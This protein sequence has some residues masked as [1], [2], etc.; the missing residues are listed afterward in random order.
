MSKKNVFRCFKYASLLVLLPTKSLAFCP[1]CTI[2]VV[3][4]VGFSRYLGIDDTI[5]ATWLGA[6]TLAFVVLTERWFDKKKIKFFLRWLLDAIIYY[7][8][9]IFALF[10]WD[11]TGHPHNK[12]IGVDKILFGMIVGTAAMALGYYVHVLLKKKNHNKSY[13]P[14]QKVVL[15]ITPLVILSIVFYF[16]TR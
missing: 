7:G 2:G 5:T 4:G 3:A 13:F 6:M 12:I 9:I 14:F 1:V 11:L 8:L 10:R 15:P 16:V